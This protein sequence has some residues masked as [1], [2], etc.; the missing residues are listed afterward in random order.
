V[1]L[2]GFLRPGDAREAEL[3]GAAILYENFALAHVN[4]H[5]YKDGERYA[6]RAV[7]LAQPIASAQDV[8]A[9]GLSLVANA[10]RYEGDLEGALRTIRQSRQLAE[11]ASYPN[12]AARLFNLYGPLL[13]EGR[14]LGE[15]DTVNLDRPAE[16]IE[17]L[18]KAMDMVEEAVHK[19]AKDAASRHRLGTVARE[20]GD[21]L[22]DTD[23]RRALAVYESGMRRLN[24]M[25]NSLAA[26]RG[27]A[28]L[29][30][31]SSYPL[32]RLHRVSEAKTRIDS[33]MEILRKIRDYPAEQI[34][35][36]SP[37]FSVVGALADHEAEAGNPQVARETYEEFLQKIMASKPEPETSLPDAARLSHIY[38]AIARLD[39]RSGR[40][41]L[42]T[43]LDSRRLEL[44]RHWNVRLP[45]NPFVMRQ[46][47][48][49][50]SAAGL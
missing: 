13:R 20:L 6:R 50:A 10:L 41:D 16:A 9:G 43:A 22:R 5:H 2:E 25:A 33:A 42:A 46:L 14:I 1:R 36:G 24:E 7:E 4:T 47:T 11:G 17:V 38:M 30:A 27:R 28:E 40:K 34:Q 32:R 48:A 39:R 15:K 12:E 8:A 26:Q 3:T 37:V 23:P 31:K 29:M 45:N 18:Q 19:D 21:I 49:E 35:L 44:W